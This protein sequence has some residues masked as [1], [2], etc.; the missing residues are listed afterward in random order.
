MEWA[1]AVTWPMYERRVERLLKRHG[2]ESYLPRCKSKLQRTVLLFPRYIF[3]GPYEKWPELRSV[4][5]INRLLKSGDHPAPVT[6]ETLRI[7][8]DKEDMEGFVKLPQHHV[9]R[10]KIGQRVRI[11]IGAFA[12]MK[13]TYRGRNNK[14]WE[15]VELALGQVVLPSG[16]CVAE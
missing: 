15:R 11:T 16:N 10:L 6:E 4:Y 9:A 8:R 2:F 3:V 14:R 13:G 5:G 7:L 1:V 12:G